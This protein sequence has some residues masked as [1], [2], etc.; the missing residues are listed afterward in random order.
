MSKPMNKSDVI[1]AI[2]TA[3]DLSKNVAAQALEAFM[4]LIMKSVSKGVPVALIGFGTFDL[5]ERAERTG[6]NPKT[7]EAIKISA[8][9]LPRFKA[10]KGFKE[11]VNK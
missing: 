11:A 3:T 10:G 4:E 6:R 1:D 5:T 7:G 8:A 2:S 9:K